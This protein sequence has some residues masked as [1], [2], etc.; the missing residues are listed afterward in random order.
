MKFFS[1]KS[2]YKAPPPPVK[3]APSKS[4]SHH[5]TKKSDKGH[6]QRGNDKGGCGRD[7]KPTA[8]TTPPTITK[9]AYG[10]N[11]GTLKVGDTITFTVTFSEAVNVAA[12]IPELVLNTEGIA[13][14]V[15]GT[16][17]ANLVFSYTVAPFQNTPDLSITG[18][19]LNSA[20]IKDAAG[21]A[22]I[23]TGAVVNPAGTVI[24]DTI[25]PDATISLDPITPD[26]VINI[27]ES[28]GTVAVTGTIG[29]EAVDGSA[30]VLTVNGN[31]Y[32]G[33]VTG[34]AFSIDI[35]GADL[36][37]D[38]SSAITAELRAADAAGNTS[39][40]TTSAS[41]G[42]ALDAPFP[43]IIVMAI[44]GD[45]IIDAAEAGGPVIITGM[46]GGLYV[47]EPIVTLTIN[48][49]EYSGP[50]VYGEF[51]IE[52]PGAELLADPYLT[53]EASVTIEDDFGNV[54][55]GAITH[56]YSNDPGFGFA[57]DDFQIFS[58]AP[59]LDSMASSFPAAAGA[60]PLAAIYGDTDANPAPLL[61][62]TGGAG[63]DFLT[64]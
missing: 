30:V 52:V 19:N 22:A 20:T 26:N 38:A 61:A 39:T 29:G 3:A 44:T 17:S 23:T 14:Y 5:D 2:A 32:T 55:T 16:G 62:F 56:T 59:A 63:D 54:G 45:D 40:A 28:G 46:I 34:G 37:A 64:V 43:A 18:L 8:D 41:Y 21:N 58:S 33:S 53:I 36:A 15:S 50:A 31:S 51:A 47:G 49:Q 24:V 57:G 11:D 13:T 10:P 12:G 6:D 25:P 60:N 27:A 35:S 42:L 48:G 4:N 7:D 1:S 9:V